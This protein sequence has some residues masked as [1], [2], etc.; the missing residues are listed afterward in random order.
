V[1]LVVGDDGESADN[2]L[3][4]R[5]SAESRASSRKPYVLSACGPEKRPSAKRISAALASSM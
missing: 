4:R 1:H 3:G 5:A 2:S